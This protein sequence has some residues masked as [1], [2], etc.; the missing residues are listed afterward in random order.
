M[1]L[2]TTVLLRIQKFLN[3]KITKSFKHPHLN[4]KKVSK[5][6]KKRKKKSTYNEYKH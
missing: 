6:S 1:L 3:I 5:M 4:E 2:L